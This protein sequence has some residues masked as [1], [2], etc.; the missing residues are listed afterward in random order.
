MGYIQTLETNLKSMDSIHIR[1][2]LRPIH[3][4]CLQF[5]IVSTATQTLTPRMAFTFASLWAQF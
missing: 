5:N 2:P 3:T 4:W 1:N